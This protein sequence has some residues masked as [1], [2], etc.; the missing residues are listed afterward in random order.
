MSGHVL[1]EGL[2]PHQC[3]SS[4]V[5]D[6]KLTNSVNHIMDDVGPS[7][8]KTETGDVHKGKKCSPKK[9]FAFK[10]FFRWK[11][12]LEPLTP[13]SDVP[14]SPIDR[15]SF[16]FESEGPTMIHEASFNSFLGLGDASRNVLGPQG[17]PDVSTGSSLDSPRRP[18][19]DR[20]SSDEGTN[21][22]MQS[23]LSDKVVVDATLVET[24]C[25]TTSDVELYLDN[26]NVPEQQHQVGEGDYDM[27][28]TDDQPSGANGAIAYA[29]T[30][31]ELP[32]QSSTNTTECAN[33]LL[34]VSIIHQVMDREEKS[35]AI[36]QTLQP[37]KSMSYSASPPDNAV[38]EI[39]S[40]SLAEIFACET[41]TITY[42]LHPHTI[43][44]GNTEIIS[45][46]ICDSHGVQSTIRHMS[47]AL[48]E[49]EMVT[50]PSAAREIL[51][52]AITAI[53]FRADTICPSPSQEIQ[54]KEIKEVN[55]EKVIPFHGHI[56][57]KS[58][59]DSEKVSANEVVP[60]APKRVNRHAFLSF[61]NLRFSTAVPK[62]ITEEKA[63]IPIAIG[64]VINGV[65]L[66]EV[67]ARCKPRIKQPSHASIEAAFSDDD[68]EGE[69]N[70]S[71]RD[72][73]EQIMAVDHNE[74]KDEKVEAQVEDEVDQDISSARQSE[75]LLASLK[76]AR[77]AKRLDYL[78]VVDKLNHTKATH[79]IAIESTEMQGDMQKPL[80]DDAQLSKESC[81]SEGAKAVFKPIVLVMPK[82]IS[83]PDGPTC[84]P[85]PREVISIDSIATTSDN[86]DGSIVDGA[87]EDTYT[88]DVQIHTS[89]EMDAADVSEVQ[90]SGASNFS[91]F[92]RLFGPKTSI[93][94]TGAMSA[95]TCYSPF[96]D[97][98]AGV[99]GEKRAISAATC[100]T[101]GEDGY[102]SNSDGEELSGI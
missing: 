87:I 32:D 3:V 35:D 63:P 75:I 21:C 37:K 92:A 47:L 91:L 23:G 88:T 48:P 102:K 74:S 54:E 94:C 96:V 64:R 77:F 6:K 13:T 16:K 59:V 26:D 15:G 73:E 25:T 70:E 11:A 46:E 36:F 44:T 10:R 61:G 52:P 14:S 12:D 100:E 45:G 38:D 30:T 22:E 39:C 57:N 40:L 71:P 5:E 56:L 89:H 55:S 98:S 53:T 24:S 18:I 84:T 33:V 34:G 69:G 8:D 90:K 93:C 28:D 51:R 82:V 58:T 101:V 83:T 97:A 20:S 60:G 66:A 42:D 29:C 4:L 76:S 85:G 1:N 78:K 41:D 99:D 86:V 81:D 72:K 65:S 9:L 80:I 50:M 17:K 43:R 68:S 31:S 79:V 19:L 2:I 27:D 67:E 95:G 62:I 7:I 49:K